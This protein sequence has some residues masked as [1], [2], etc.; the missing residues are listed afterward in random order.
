VKG[1]AGISG[2][3]LREKPGEYAWSRANIQDAYRTQRADVL[4]EQRRHRSFELR[5]ANVES[6]VGSPRTSAP[7]MAASWHVA[8][9]R[10]MAALPSATRS[11]EDAS[12][13]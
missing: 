5:G 7:A 2:Q 3:T 6:S 1:L 11:R 10:A 8:H 9:V 12:Y 13:A 4:R